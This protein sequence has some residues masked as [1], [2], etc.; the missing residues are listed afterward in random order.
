MIYDYD[1]K[2]FLLR[3][4]RQ[5]LQ[6]GAAELRFRSGVQP[7]VYVAGTLRP[8]DAPLSSVELIEALHEVCISGMRKSEL[9][10]QTHEFH[11][12]TF[13]SVGR[14]KCQY[15]SSFGSSSL[16]FFLDPGE[17]DFTS[18]EPK[19][20]LPQLGSQQSPTSS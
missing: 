5:A 6:A 14:V 7:M 11:F 16:T 15:G 3:N 19:V 10:A 1:P 20:K 4:L 9:Q 12:V 2:P 17:Y 18:H 8:V 13:R